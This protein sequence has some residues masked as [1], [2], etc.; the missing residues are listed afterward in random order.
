MHLLRFGMQCVNIAVRQIRECAQFDV[1]R[2]STETNKDNRSPRTNRGLEMSDLFFSADLVN[3]QKDCDLQLF[4]MFCIHEDIVQILPFQKKE[5]VKNI[6]LCSSLIW[7][8]PERIFPNNS[9]HSCWDNFT[10]FCELKKQ[11][12]VRAS[13]EQLWCEPES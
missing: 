12:L 7:R 9:C 4:P 6:L 10:F 11:L 13:E 3:Q 1:T 5:S 8:K 2:Y